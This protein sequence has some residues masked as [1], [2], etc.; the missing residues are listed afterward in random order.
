MAYS[1]EAYSKARTELQRR[2][3]EAEND[4]KKRHDEVCLRFPEILDIEREMARTGAE[5]IRAVG[6][7]KDAEEYIDKIAKANLCAQEM[8]KTILT[9]NGYPEDY[10]D[11]HYTCPVCEDT[12][13]DGQNACRCY[14]ELVKKYAFESVTKGSLM[15][16]MTFDSFS[17]GFYPDTRDAESG[18]IPRE[19][20][21]HILDFCKMYADG[22]SLKSESLLLLG[23]TG[24]GKT[25]L[26]L[27]IAGKVT[28][29]GY[30]VIYDSAQNIINRIEKE[31]FGRGDSG[32]DTLSDVCGCDLLILDDLGTEFQTNFTV[33]TIY[34]IVNNRTLSSLPTIISTNLD[35]SG[36]TEK[37]GERVASR[38]VGGFFT[39]GFCGNDIRQLK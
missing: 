15:S 10:L 36:L 37:Y 33:S 35:H 16:E 19:H 28:D 7:G 31:H 6:L 13:Y 20:M 8:R 9:S 22:F 26:S 14:F 23:R 27:A 32:S 5:A 4:R 38:I 18:V 12:G 21:S 24:L 29:K 1:R 34:N 2:R 11:I 3:T 30:S 17:L 39:L 25:H